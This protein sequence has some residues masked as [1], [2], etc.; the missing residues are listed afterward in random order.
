[1]AYAM[2]TV[3]VEKVMTCVH[4]YSCGNSEEETPYD[5]E[6]A[7]STWINKVRV[8]FPLTEQYD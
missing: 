2:E 6:D 5:T 3:S 4:Q 1:M 7:V 8:C